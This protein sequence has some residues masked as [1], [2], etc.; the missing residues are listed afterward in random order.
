MTTI[1]QLPKTDEGRDAV[2]V[3]TVTGFWPLDIAGEAGQPVGVIVA[4][5]RPFIVPASSEYPRVG[6][7]DPFLQT[8]V[9]AAK[10]DPVSLEAL[11]DRRSER[12]GEVEWDLDE[13]TAVTVFLD[14]GTT[15]SL[16]HVWDHPVLGDYEMLVEGEPGYADECRGC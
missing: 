10:W 14:P 9:P 12:W 3:A 16:R 4:N 1:G 11:P 6:I 13:G 2:H 15:K 5:G 7:I 8:P